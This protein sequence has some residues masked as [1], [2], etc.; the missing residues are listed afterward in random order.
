[1]ADAIIKFP[2]PLKAN[3]KVNSN[4]AEKLQKIFSEEPEGNAEV[5]SAIQLLAVPNKLNTKPDF[6]TGGERNPR[7]GM[8]MSFTL[9]PD[10]DKAPVGPLNLPSAPS[11]FITADTLEDIRER[12]IF[13]LDRAIKLSKIAEE[14]PDGYAAYE[15]AIYEKAI[16]QQTMARQAGKSDDSTS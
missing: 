2:G 7:W 3:S 16:M 5:Y 1:M 13:E 11:Q 12:V 14:D 10:L 9:L 6:E 8:V 4:T 15:N